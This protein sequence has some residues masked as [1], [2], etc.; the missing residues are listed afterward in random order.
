MGAGFS[1]ASCD[2]EIRG[3]GDILGGSQSGH[4]EAIGLELYMELLK[5]AINEIRG[6]K[7]VLKKDIEFSTPFAAHLPHH[8]I[9]DASERL[10]YYKKISNCETIKDLQ[11][12]NEEIEDIFGQLPEEARN[13][14]SLIE[15]RVYLQRPLGV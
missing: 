15:T 11:D 7:K 1:L 6:E 2:L 10:R 14:V 8:F 13:L 4:I 5:E 3:A 12:L 9:Q